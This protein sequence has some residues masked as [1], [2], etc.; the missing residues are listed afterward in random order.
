MADEVGYFRQGFEIAARATRHV[1]DVTVPCER[2][3]FALKPKL[4]NERMN[5]GLR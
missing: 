3:S 2:I 5:F 1:S 4:D